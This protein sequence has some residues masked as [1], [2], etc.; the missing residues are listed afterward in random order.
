MYIS[1]I[2]KLYFRVE[3]K[4]QARYWT[5]G[6]VHTTSTL[7]SLPYFAHRTDCKVLSCPTPPG[8]VECWS[9]SYSL[10]CPSCLPDRTNTVKNWHSFRPCKLDTI[11]LSLKDTWIAHPFKYTFN[12]SLRF[13]FNGCL[14]FLKVWN[15]LEGI[16]SIVALEN[17]SSVMKVSD[18]SQTNQ[19]SLLSVTQSWTTCGH[20]ISCDS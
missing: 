16:F 12:I 2:H 8:Q 5:Y 15:K 20:K 10:S 13:A 4:Q 19:P 7:S 3:N 17:A 11:F 14:I 9:S 18:V 1:S 6:S